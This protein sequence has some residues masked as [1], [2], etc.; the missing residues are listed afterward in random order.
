MT[1]TFP[2]PRDPARDIAG[3]DDEEVRLAALQEY[4]ILD[5]EP[6]RG[7]D[8]I[9]LIASQICQTPVA[10]VSFVASDRQWFKARIGFDPCQTPLSQSVCAHGL[11]KPGLLVIPDLTADPRSRDNTLV[12]GEPHIRF[13]AGARLETADGVGLGMLCVI[14]TVARPGGLTAAQGEALIALAG[15]VMAQLEL[16]RMNAQLERVIVER[17][18]ARARIWAVTPDLLSVITN[19]GRFDATNP[20][21]GATL[22]WSEAEL[23]ATPVVQFVLP[24]D[25]EATNAVWADAVERGQPVLRFENRY[26]CKDGGWRWLSWVGVPKGDKVYCSARDVTENK[27]RDAALAERTAERD[28]MWQ[29]S[30]D[31]LLLLG[32]DGVFRRVNPAWREVLGYDGDDLIGTRVDRLVHPDDVELTERALADASAGR[33]PIVENRYRHKDGSYRWV[34]W[35]AAPAG[36]LIYATGRHVTAEHEAAEA[37]ARAEEQLRQAQKMEAI[38]QLTGGIAHDFNNLLTGI[39]GSLELMQVRMAQGRVGDVD[40][41]LAAAQGAAKRAAALTHRLLAFS[42]RQTLAPKPTDVRALVNGMADLISR[43]VGPS[44]ELEVVHAAG[45]WPSLI[46]P[47]Q[48]ENAVLN[49]CINARDAMPDGGKITI[50]TGNRRMDRQAAHQRGLEPGQY[51]SLC[52]SDTG[53]GMA[54]DVVARV[55]EPFFTT[56]PIGM[57]TGLGLSMIH[58]F[59]QQSGGTVSIYS[60]IGQGTTVRIYLPRHAGPADGKAGAEGDG[61]APPEAARAEAGE[62]VLVVDDEPTVRMLVADVLT[63]LGYTA[64]EAGDGAAGLRVVNSDVRIDLLVTDVG[65]PGGMNGRQVADAA[66]VARPELKVLFITGYAENAVLSHGHLDPGMHVLTKPFAIEALASQI[67]DLIAG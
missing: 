62:T 32:T 4:G 47:S 45:L 44:V 63:D 58:G 52:V 64:I 31:L 43:S 59:A 19:D 56:K 17:G 14:D 27:A 21:W 11:A 30:P 48:L 61:A 55:F 26:R 67:R 3:R 46:D 36:E 25:I 66:R 49:L 12:T 13:Y 5:T 50:E 6:E 39:T 41:Y 9:V 65:L 10:L 42:R 20:A 54:P 60:E 18:S 2:I 24:D 35:A 33:L 37:L 16:H 40:R 38:G 15:Q 57:G 34:A 22:G 7:F 28:L 8:D 23:A 53:T 51:V 1:S 29:T